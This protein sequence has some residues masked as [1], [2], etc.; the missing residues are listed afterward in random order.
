MNKSESPLNVE[1]VPADETK[2]SVDKDKLERRKQWIK[3]LSSDIYLNE[4][5][6]V[7]ND[8]I[9]QGNFAKAN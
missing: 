3:N 7:V 9:K 5:V 4:T 8:M 2:L 6:N 1:L